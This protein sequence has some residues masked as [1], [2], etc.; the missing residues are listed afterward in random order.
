MAIDRESF[1]TGMRRLAAGVCVITSVAEGG[2]RCGLTA[3]AV[4]AVSADPPTLLVCVN[5]ATG[6]YAAMSAAKHFAVNLLSVE[7]KAVANRFA[8][9]IAP[10]ER[11]SQGS[12]STLVTGWPVLDSAVAVFD[13]VVCQ[14]VEVGTHGVLFGGIEA[15]RFRQP[16]VKPLLYAHGVYGRFVAVDGAQNGSRDHVPPWISPD[17]RFLEDGLRWGF[18][19]M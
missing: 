3:T 10:E 11:F 5:S 15:L 17:S 18:M 4:C 12:W 1:K 2:R 14:V 9:A 16:H 8:S 6:S 13:C 19:W 7:D